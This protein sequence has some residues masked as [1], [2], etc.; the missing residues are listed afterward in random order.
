[1]NDTRE[2]DFQN[3]PF[4]LSDFE[5]VGEEDRLLDCLSQ[6]VQFCPFSERFGQI[7]IS[8]SEAVGVICRG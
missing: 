4:V 2:F 6:P 5:C 1:M 8:S 3:N 7:R